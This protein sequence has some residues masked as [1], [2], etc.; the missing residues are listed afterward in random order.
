MIGIVG[1]A[2]EHAA[3][4][5][6]MELA[7]PHVATSDALELAQVINGADLFVGNQSFPLAVAEALKKPVVV[8]VDPGEPNCCFS[9]H[10]ARYCW[11]EMP[12]LPEL[13]TAQ[14]YPAALGPPTPPPLLCPA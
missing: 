3:L 12:P 2:A 5:N 7:A 1:S 8:E 13:S 6:A 4:C 14:T 9:R 11:G 10:T